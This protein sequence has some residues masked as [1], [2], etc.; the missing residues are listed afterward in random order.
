VGE[1]DYHSGST[2]FLDL[3]R[4][5]WKSGACNWSTDPPAF[6]I[7]PKY[8]S[9]QVVQAKLDP[10]WTYFVYRSVVAGKIVMSGAE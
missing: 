9:L 3:V 1:L 7:M 4:F 6:K 5:H 10:T 2:R 8:G